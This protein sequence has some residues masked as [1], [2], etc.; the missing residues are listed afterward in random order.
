MCVHGSY[1][2]NPA[3][4]SVT[5][6]TQPVA[7]GRPGALDQLVDVAEDEHAL[8]DGLRCVGLDLRREVKRSPG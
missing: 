6:G 8:V 1:L 4:A 2:A 5:E 7:H 3:G